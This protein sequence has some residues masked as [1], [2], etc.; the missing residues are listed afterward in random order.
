LT[1]HARRI[2]KGANDEARYAYEVE[3]CLSATQPEE[4]CQ[5]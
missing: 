1:D 4:K 5:A 2:R 3:C